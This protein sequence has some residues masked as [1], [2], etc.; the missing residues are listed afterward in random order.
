MHERQKQIINDIKDKM[1]AVV[2]PAARLEHNL[3]L[4][5]ALFILPLFALANAGIKI[6]FSSIFSTILEPVSLGIIA[7]LIL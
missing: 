4:P 2:T 1:N 5:V 6:D 7:G 3:H